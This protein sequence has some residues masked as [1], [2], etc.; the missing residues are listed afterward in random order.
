MIS[1]SEP[2]GLFS[3]LLGMRFML[4]LPI[5]TLCAAGVHAWVVYAAEAFVA[6]AEASPLRP[7]LSSQ[8]SP[9]VQ[10]SPAALADQLVGLGHSV[11]ML[12]LARA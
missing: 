8:A 3:K 4:V 10:V 6:G 12:T 5:A 11:V 9:D 1:V 7:A 2:A